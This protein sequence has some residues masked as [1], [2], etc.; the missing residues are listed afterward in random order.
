MA[1][2]APH[3]KVLRQLADAKDDYLSGALDFMWDGGKATVFVVFGQPSHATFESDNRKLEGEAAVD[4][5]LTELPRSYTVSPWRRAMSPEET[6]TLTLDELAQPFAQ[7]AGSQGDEPADAADF[8]LWSAGDDSPELGFNLADFP[9][10]PAGPALWEPAPAAD[11]RLDARLA[12]LPPALVVLTGPR[13][14]AAGVVSGGELIDAVWVDADD[15]ARGESAAMALVG[16]REGVLS[17]YRLEPPELAEAIPALWRFPVAADD[18]ELA[19]ID[20]ASLA[21]SLRAGGK[22]RAVIVDAP[23]KGVAL[24]SRGE[25]VAVYSESERA[26]SQSPEALVALFSQRDGIV[27]VLERTGGRVVLDLPPDD[28]V[29][30]EPISLHAPTPEPPPLHPPEPP[31]LVE[32]VASSSFVDFEEVKRELAAISVAWL[33]DDG[34]RPVMG[35]IMGTRPTIDDVVATIDTIRGLQL[36]A[37]E[38]SAISSMAREMHHH[39]AERLCGA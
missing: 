21:A 5:M 18:I 32:D 39:A 6:L 23:E 17:G 31:P 13:L 3:V 10:L 1:T 37:Q 20:P 30:P 24:F 29:P 36:P 2:A 4:A 8:G 19:W 33:G 22:D 34:A 12:G 35:L 25:L 27:R 7:L 28:A 14:R 9:L 11:V 15:A 38:P 16:A 26:P